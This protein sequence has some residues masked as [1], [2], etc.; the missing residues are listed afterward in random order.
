MKKAI[1]LISAA[2]LALNTLTCFA[3]YT[4]LP[5]D[6]KGYNAAERLKSF[7]I[8]TGYEDE[9]FKPESTLTRAEAAKLLSRAINTDEDLINNIEVASL[10]LSDITKQHWA[11][12]YIG[13]L[14]LSGI[15]SGYED[16][17]FR[18]E[19]TVTYNEFIKMTVAILGYSSIAEADGGYPPGYIKMSDSLGITKNIYYSGDSAITRRDAAIIINTALDVPLYVSTG[20]DLS[21]DGKYVQQ[22]DIQNGTGKEY[23]TLLTQMHH[24]YTVSGT[25]GADGNVPLFSINGV[26]AVSGADT[27][28]RDPVAAYKMMQKLGVISD[29]DDINVHEPVQ[30]GYFAK[31]AA[32]LIT[33]ETF[34]K[35]FPTLQAVTKDADKYYSD[36][37]KTFYCYSGI[38][39]MT[40]AGYMS[41]LKSNKFMAEETMSRDDVLFI[42]LKAAGEDVSS[43]SSAKIAKT[44]DKLGITKYESVYEHDVFDTGSLIMLLAGLADYAG[45]L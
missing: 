27:T 33:N 45:L 24:I 17:T 12:G 16:G 6:D 18:P 38:D 9:S 15:I 39:V 21:S 1:L 4:D 26:K 14:A 42:L 32:R 11:A 31:Y 10:N 35:K 8:M 43:Y 19:N 34:A 25:I 29:K 23:Q 37:P 22:F 13:A 30:R 28:G 7:N 2:A 36:V 41:Y 5:K 44:A 20:F 40:K 3:D